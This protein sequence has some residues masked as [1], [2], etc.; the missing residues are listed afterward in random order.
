MN[1]AER[2][3]RYTY[4]ETKLNANTKKQQFPL[5]SRATLQSLG[6]NW[7][8]FFTF[9]KVTSVYSLEKWLLGAVLNSGESILGWYL[10]MCQLLVQ[11]LWEKFRTQVGSKP[12]EGK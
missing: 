6:I 7:M 8:G 3:Q 5:T 11:F 12:D 9:K 4:L 1:Y 2:K 10:Q